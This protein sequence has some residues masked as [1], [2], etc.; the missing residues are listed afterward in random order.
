MSKVLVPGSFDPM[1]LG[2]I[3]IIKRCSAIFDKVVVMVGYNENKKGL[4]TA[5][6]RLRFACDALKDL[7]NVEV[8]VFGGL[9]TDFAHENDIDMI[10]KG[11]RN[12][13]D[14]S[15]ESEMAYVNSDISLQKYG[16]RT[17]TLFMNSSPEM[18]YTSSSLVRKLLALNLP[19]EKYVH[20]PA[21]LNEIITG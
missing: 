4:L 11:I 15:Y 13:E 18:V 17:E 16:K 19:V 14:L 6:Q 8:V 5:D 2:H 9:V 12:E 3:E 21:L 7:P 20:A 1:T 10:V